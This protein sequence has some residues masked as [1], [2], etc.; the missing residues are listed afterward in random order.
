MSSAEVP[1]QIEICS[2]VMTRVTLSYFI[3]EILFLK[4]RLLAFYSQSAIGVRTW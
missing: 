2:D 1:E 3:I 4:G